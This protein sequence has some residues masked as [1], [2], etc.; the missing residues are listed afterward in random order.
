LGA[1]FGITIT[2]EFGV[3]ARYRTAI[4]AARGE[5]RARGVAPPS[6]R[7]EAPPFVP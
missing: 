1:V 7:A 2:T 6:G 3:S 5:I 4:T